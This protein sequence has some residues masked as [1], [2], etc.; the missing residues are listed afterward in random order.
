MKVHCCKKHVCEKKILSGQPNTISFIIA[1]YVYEVVDPSFFN[2]LRICEIK[3]RVCIPRC[4]FS[5]N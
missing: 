1:L 5:V 3:T 2:I 4:D